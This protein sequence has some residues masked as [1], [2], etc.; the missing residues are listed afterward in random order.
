MIYCFSTGGNLS[1]KITEV[2]A[3][4][5]GEYAF[6]GENSSGGSVQIGSLHDKPGVGPMQFLLLG[7]AGCT[8]SDIV[9]ILHKK[10]IVLDDLQI[11]VRASRA[12]TYPMIWE[13]IHVTY[14]LWGKE[15]PPKAVE[16]AIHLSE[17]KYCSVGIMLAETA[18]LTNEYKILMPGTPADSK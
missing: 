18:K 13:T 8:G 16:Q 1:Q 4:W 5:K 6:L 3:S 9:N 11:L 7:L 12:E 15:I 17:T 14:L 2:K 10:G